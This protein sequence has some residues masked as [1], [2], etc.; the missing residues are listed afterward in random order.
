MATRSGQTALITGA[1]SGIGYELAKCFAA[2]GHDLI[3]VSRSRGV[4]EHVARELSATHGI[5]AR[6]LPADLF[7][8][9]AARRVYDQV[10]AWGRPV[11]FLV[12][13]AGQ[14]VY[15]RFIDTDLEQELR[16]ITL[17]ISAMVVLTKLF[18][19]DMVLRD[20]GRVLQVSSVVS[21]IPAPY[22]AVYSGTKAF[23]HNFTEALI[24]E[25][26][27]TH[28]TLTVLRPGATDTDFFA[29]AG[30]Q[31]ARFVV[32]GTLDDPAEVAAEGYRALMH[33]DDQIVTGLANKAADAAARMMPDTVLAG[34]M[35]DASE[36]LGNEKDRSH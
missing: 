34:R 17:N 9:A 15:G 36:P 32:T 6:A 29:K 35:R 11:D 14:G 2:D 1:S 13:D 3:L 33:G 26:R 18:V 24:A 10:R 25:L 27:D 28:V 19:R 20:E 23:I 8:P 30:A 5:E 16:V 21:R 4:L 12:N 22:Q 31:N 7:D